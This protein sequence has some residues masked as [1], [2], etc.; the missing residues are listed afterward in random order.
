MEKQKK[1][2]KNQGPHCQSLHDELQ[3]T[4]LEVV[5]GSSYQA[6]RQ[7]WYQA[8]EGCDSCTMP[9][10]ITILHST[11]VT[12]SL[13]TVPALL[14]HNLTDRCELAIPWRRKVSRAL[15]NLSP[16]HWC[17]LILCLSSLEK[18]T[19]QKTTAKATEQLCFYCI[20]LKYAI[21]H[22]SPKC[23]LATSQNFIPAVVFD[24]RD[25][26]HHVAETPQ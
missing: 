5:R 25:K 13:P 20:A 12:G 14:S 8:E 23:Y 7:L 21:C 11:S 6:V 15:S 17:L 2:K 9:C 18:K 1:K 3:L 26:I 22:C 19:P 10:H 24:I 4:G 16:K